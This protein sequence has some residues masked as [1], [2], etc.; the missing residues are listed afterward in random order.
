MP[1]S[2]NDISLYDEVVVPDL[3]TAKSTSPLKE[4]GLTGLKRASGIID[5]EFLP[6]LRGRKAIQIYREMS[7][8]DPTVGSLL[9][10]INQLLRAVTWR[11]EAPD[12]T[13]DSTKASD[14]IES[15][16]DDMSHT[17]DDMV[18]DILTSLVYGWSWHEIVYK[19]RVGPWEKDPKKKSKYSD[20]LIGWRKIPIRAQETMLR[21]VFDED[22]GIKGMV[23][24][25]PPY[26]QSVLIPIE[27]SLL[28][29]F[30][31]VKGNPE[32]VSM[33]RTPTGPGSSRSAWRSSRPSVSSVTS[34]VCPW[35]RCRS[36][37]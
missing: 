29:R 1:Q 16:M 18:S 9:F 31:S 24:L 33:L 22:G 11:V 15:C 6:A 7:N 26:Y 23:Q 12:N 5:E 2:P 34:R 10:T 36:S 14:F 19:K 25:S 27:K 35:P 21:W 17:W 32:G 28:F 30:S 13:P 3:D 4:M 37:T 8:N 20:G